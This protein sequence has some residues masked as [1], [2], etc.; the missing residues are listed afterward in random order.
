[1]IDAKQMTAACIIA[2]GLIAP[3][4][5]LSL[6]AV[7]DALAGGL[8]TVCYGMTKYDRPV[9][10][11]DHY[12]R[13]QCLQ[14][15]IA[16]I[17]KYGKGLDPCIKTTVTNHQVAA[18]IDAGYNLGDPTI[19][20]STF[21]RRLNEDDPHAC[22]SLIVFTHASGKWIYGLERRRKAEIKTCYTKDVVDAAIH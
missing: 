1:M 4:E 6:H 5:G 8:P 11:G 19:C 14:F 7:P 10:L 12:T 18:A 17:P 15:L 13:E 20:R 16:D 9:K 3:F 21:M 2:A 22:D